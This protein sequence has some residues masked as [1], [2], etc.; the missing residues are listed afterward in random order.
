MRLNMGYFI[1]KLENLSP[2]LNLGYLKYITFKLTEILFLLIILILDSYP[3]HN[4]AGAGKNL[5]AR[6]LPPQ[7]ASGGF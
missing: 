7:I 5:R 4:W 3:P 2:W 1:K 6:K